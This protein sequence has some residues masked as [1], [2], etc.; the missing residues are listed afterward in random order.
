MLT[1]I[2][3]E[4][5]EAVKGIRDELRKHREINWEQRRCEIDY[6]IEGLIKEPKK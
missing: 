1:K 5:M 4:A 3:M 6:L 2:D